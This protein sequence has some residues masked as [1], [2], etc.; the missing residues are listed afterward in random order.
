MSKYEADQESRKGIIYQGSSLPP[1]E[2]SLTDF[3]L[4]QNN[5]IQSIPSINSLILSEQSNPYLPWSQQIADNYFNSKNVDQSIQYVYGSPK[6]VSYN[7]NSIAMP[8]KLNFSESQDKVGMTS[9]D[10]GSIIDYHN[11]FSSQNTQYLCR[12]C[13]LPN[14][15]K[16][17]IYCDD[18]SSKFSK[19]PI[20]KLERIQEYSAI[21][22]TQ[23]A[24]YQIANYNINPAPAISLEMNF[25]SQETINAILIETTS[26]LPVIS[27][28]Q[29]G[30]IR[31]FRGGSKMVYFTGLKL[32]KMAPIKSDLSNRNI[33]VADT[34]FCIRF[35]IGSTVWFSDSFKIVSSCSQLPV[36]IR[37]SVRPSKKIPE[38]TSISPEKL[39]QETTGISKITKKRNHAFIC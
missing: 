33:K 21:V 13:K 17:R 32:N 38:K 16:D 26:K 14:L 35:S 20:R 6:K 23:P 39:V 1:I 28:F 30:E 12:N 22:L 9:P 25:P 5:S 24:K 34:T 2:T 29:T 4:Q 8:S 7:Q 36:E 10:N 3:S 18:C 11:Y 27:G 19:T 31:V 15:Q 37:N